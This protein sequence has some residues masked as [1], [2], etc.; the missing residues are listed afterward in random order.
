M[1]R[2]LNGQMIAP[3]NQTI[4]SIIVLRRYMVGQKRFEIAIKRKER[5]LGRELELPEFMVEMERASGTALDLSLSQLQVI[6]HEN[7]FARA[8]RELPRGLFR[9]P[10][11]ER[12]GGSEGRIVRLFCGSQLAALEQEESDLEPAKGAAADIDSV[13]AVLRKAACPMTMLQI[14]EAVGWDIGPYPKIIGQLEANG[15]IE[16]VA[17]S[18]RWKPERFAVVTGDSIG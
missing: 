15:E 16:V 3:Q 6:V 12:Y 13:R 11:D 17:D 10:Y 5:Q 18:V 8:G 1:F 2:Y 7:P 9:S 14:S 4:S